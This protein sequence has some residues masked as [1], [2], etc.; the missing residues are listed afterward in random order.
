MA[1]ILVGFSETRGYYTPTVK[2]D[3]LF[4]QDVEQSELISFMLKF[5]KCNKLQLVPCEETS[6]RPY[7]K[8][9]VDYPNGIAVFAQFKTMSELKLFCKSFQMP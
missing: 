5:V 2:V 8:V 9:N 1:D 4:S 7:P 3:I 6:N